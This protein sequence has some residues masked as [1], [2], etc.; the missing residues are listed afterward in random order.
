MNKQDF[1]KLQSD[2]H[3][4]HVL[5]EGNACTSHPIFMVQ[6]LSTVWGI[7]PEY[8]Y[9][10]TEIYDNDNAESYSSI[11]DFLVSQDEDF[12]EA[13]LTDLCDFV[14]EDYESGM[15]CK[16][17]VESE[18]EGSS[19]KSENDFVEFFKDR[20]VEITQCYGR[21]QWEDVTMFFTRGKA[22]EFCDTFGYRHGKL[23]VYVKSGWESD[24][25]T[26]NT[27]NI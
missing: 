2:L 17:V 18:L 6:K 10:V 4:H 19:W 9:D 14:S 23:R 5:C 25:K 1:E 16:S 11:V 7:D 27:C 26:G 15:T 24:L 22:E 8:S 12:D 3:K 21:Y 20:G 13:H